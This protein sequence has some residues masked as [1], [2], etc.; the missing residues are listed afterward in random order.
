MIK[1]NST[2]APAG[3]VAYV[4]GRYIPHGRAGVHIEDRSLQLGDGI[5]EVNAVVGGQPINQDYHL[6]R[7]A[8]S[9]GELGIAMPM[10]AAVR[11][12]LPPNRLICATR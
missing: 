11:E 7:M 4:N 8:R 1:W 6:Q 5:Y 10:K 12:I 9:L 3:R 2:R